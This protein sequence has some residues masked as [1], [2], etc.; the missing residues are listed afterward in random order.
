MIAR[1]ILKDISAFKITIFVKTLLLWFT[2][3]TL[4]F[5]RMSPPNGYIFHACMTIIFASSFYSFVEK[6]H[7]TE[8]LTCSLPV[9]RFLVV[10]ARYLTTAVIAAAGI[11]I[12]LLL[13]YIGGL[14]YTNNATSFY[15]IYNI[16]I[17]FT[18]LFTVTVHAAIFLPAVFRFNIIGTIT[19]FAAAFVVSLIAGV[20]IFQ[21][22]GNTFTPFLET[23]DL[24]R[25]SLLI[26]FM[27][28]LLVF[29]VILSVSLYKK[30]DL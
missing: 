18:V 15:D 5:F 23:D 29:S 25:T 14:L 21:Y 28:I 2:F 10:A 9:T 1:L 8:V 30:R 27:T 11:I 19:T 12:W 17:L 16:K 4:T 6:Y 20:N 26:I 13:A 7:N 24:L 3:S 22:F